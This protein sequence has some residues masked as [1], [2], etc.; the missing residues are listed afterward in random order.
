M[1]KETVIVVFSC[2]H[3]KELIARAYKAM[4]WA[5]ENEIEPILIL[6]GNDA[7]PVIDILGSHKVIWEDKSTT[8]E[9]NVCNVLE[10]INRYWIDGLKRAWVS[11]WYHIPRI[12]L[13]LRRAGI[14]VKRETFVK[15]YSGI[16]LI[17]VLVE[18]FALLAAF[19]CINHWPVITCI[20]RRLGYNV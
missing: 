11:S 12:K 2:R 15:S 14:K 5:L 8:T 16:Q 20:K 19:F 13:L 4:S 6:T 9:E 1:G 18:P 10:T 7:Q 17:N 3:R